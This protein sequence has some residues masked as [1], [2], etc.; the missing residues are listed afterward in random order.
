M[1]RYWAMRRSGKGNPL[2]LK[3]FA[4]VTLSYPGYGQPM[5]ITWISAGM[6]DDTPCYAELW[7]NEGGWSLKETQPGL[8][9]QDGICG[10]SHVPI[11][12][13]LARSW[14]VVTPTQKWLSNQLEWFA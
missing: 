8:V 12:D 4:V 13:C 6:P 10:F 2:G 1:G 11:D 7:T 5:S 3:P 14:L 9:I